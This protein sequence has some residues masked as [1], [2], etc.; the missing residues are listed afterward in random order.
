MNIA[1][2]LIVATVGRTQEMW[3]LLSSLL[4]QTVRDFE[5]I[6][7]DQ[8]DDSRL[9]PI[10]EQARS[11]GLSIRHIKQDE[12]NVSLARNV[13]AQAALSDIVAFPDDDCWYESDVIECVLKLFQRYPNLV[14]IA[15][16]WMER[17][18]AEVNSYDLSWHSMSRF[19]EINMSSIQLF[20]RRQ[21]VLELGGFDESLGVS[22]WYGAGE[23]TD[24]V[25]RCVR[26]NQKMLYAPEIC[27]HHAW[28][29]ESASGTHMDRWRR[30]RSRARGT[31]ALYARHLLPRYV[32]LR[33]LVAPLLRCLVPP[34]RSRDIATHL[35]TSLGRWEGYARW[36]RNEK[37]ARGLSVA[38]GNMDGHA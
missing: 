29:R 25:M 26:L 6:V 37:R 15:G 36:R 5:V 19:R 14:G 21:V 20:F 24:L 28:S 16:R 10:V 4:S 31:G 1:M 8:N 11:A 13:G 27:I 23:D 3:R 12:K 9:F 17:P 32:I 7:V 2:S 38:Q 30:A 22:R 34:Y 33:G 18:G 35:A